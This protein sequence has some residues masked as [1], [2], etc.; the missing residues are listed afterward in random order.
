MTAGRILYRGPSALNGEP[1]V[2]VST[3]E[4]GRSSNR[5]TGPM[6]QTWILHGT[7]DPVAASRAAEDSAVCGSCPHRWALGGACYVN[8]GQAPGS[9]YRAAMA[10]AYPADDGSPF[11]FPVRV[12]SY[13][14]PAAVPVQVW[15]SVLARAP[16]A[17]TGYTH[18]WRR[19]PALKG[20]CMASVDTPREREQAKAAGWRTFRTR[21]A[22]APLLA[23]EIDC[24]ADAGLT[25]C[26]SCGLCNG[27]AGAGD[28]RRDIS[29]QLHGAR[30]PRRVAAG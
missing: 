19:G 13:G 12:G 9:V 10:G 14:D 1:I 16:R 5:K 17:R 11:G 15:R 20:V 27:A 23:G 21:A 29:I 25:D 7:L 2:C 3:G 24:P 26:A 6:V 30:A 28:R 8:I 18:Q 22:G 4:D